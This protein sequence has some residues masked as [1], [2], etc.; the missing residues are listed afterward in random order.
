MS[1]R[2]EG[3]GPHPAQ[4]R[5]AAVARDDLHEARCRARVA[6]VADP[7]LREP[8]RARR[9]EPLQ[10][11]RARDRVGPCECEVP[12]AGLDDARVR[13]EVAV[14]RE[15]HTICPPDRDAR[16]IDAI[17]IA[18]EISARARI[19]ER[20]YT[21]SRAVTDQVPIDQRGRLRI[22]GD[23]DAVVRPLLLPVA[24]E[25]LQPHFVAAVAVVEPAHVTAAVR[26]QRDLVEHLLAGAVGDREVLRRVG[27][28]LRCR[29]GRDE[30]ERDEGREGKRRAHAK[31]SRV[32]GSGNQRGF[33]IGARSQPWRYRRGPDGEL[34]R[35]P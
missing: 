18:I 15:R 31:R 27:R 21:E 11:H 25:P 32:G 17:G 9:I 23:H 12:V 19:R 4:D 28:P 24:V 14:G 22:V 16:R 3:R 6:G 8:R 20:Q 13:F 2:R 5:T 29:G 10:S 34:L 1:R 35:E 7:V 33:A 26:Q 30:G